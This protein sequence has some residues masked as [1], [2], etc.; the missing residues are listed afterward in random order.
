MPDLVLLD[1]MLPNR[2]G[3][4]ILKKCQRQSINIW[5]SCHFTYC[6][7]SEKDKVEGFGAGADDYITKPF[8]PMS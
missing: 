6:P 2:Y 1:V 8:L 5:N 7:I 3:T 4:E